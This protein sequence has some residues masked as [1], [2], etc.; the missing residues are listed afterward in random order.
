M[1]RLRRKWLRGPT[2][3]IMRGMEKDERALERSR[4][5]ALFTTRA[6][7]PADRA[8]VAHLIRTVMPEFGA[9][10]PGFAIND[11]EVDDMFAAYEAARSAYFV[12][13]RVSDGSVA[14]GAGYAPLVGGDGATCELRKMYFM[15]ELRGLGLG[16]ELLSRCIIGAR[17][18]GFARMYL[19]TLGGMAQARALYERSGFTRID[20]PLG[21][22]GHFSCDAFYVR[23]LAPD[24]AK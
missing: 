21:A 4:R 20:G 22:T 17:E 12:V 11:P 3:G 1:S 5:R 15:P 10:G 8:G 19:E 14:G 2:I 13:T 23:S 9:R 24:V 16:Q 6:L 18:A 7:E